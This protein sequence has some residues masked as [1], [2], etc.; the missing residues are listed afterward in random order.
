MMTLMC[1]KWVGDYFTHG[2]YDV[3]I[4][5]KGSC[6][7]FVGVCALSSELTNDYAPRR[8]SDARMGRTARDAQIQSDERHEQAGAALVVFFVK[9]FLTPSKGPIV[10]TRRHC[11]VSVA[12][13]C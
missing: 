9:L 2:I 3:T 13:V 1:C 4:E 6:L 8:H 5:L 7:M 10:A 11:R 12:C